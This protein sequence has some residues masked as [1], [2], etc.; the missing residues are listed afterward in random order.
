M[1]NLGLFTFSTGSFPIIPRKSFNLFINI[2]GVSVSSSL[3]ISQSLSKSILVVSL[4]NFHT[5][6]IGL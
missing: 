6:Y 5:S 4:N 3:N 2:E 1:E